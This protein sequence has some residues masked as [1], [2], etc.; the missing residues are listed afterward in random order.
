[1]TSRRPANFRAIEILGIL[2]ANG[3]VSFKTLMKLVDPP[4][5]EKKLRMALSRLLKKDVIQ[6]RNERVFGGHGTFYQ[7]SQGRR[8]RENAAEIL[9]CPSKYLEQPEFR[10]REL[11]HNDACAL[12]M[13]AIFH[14]LPD[15]QIIRDFEF[16]TNA[17][18]RKV[19]SLDIEDIDL[20]P[21]L[22]LVLRCDDSQSRIVSIAVE[23]EKTRKSDSRIIRKLYKY[24]NRSHV[25]GV[26]Y[27]CESRRI[28]DVLQHIFVTSVSH[29]ARR[30]EHYPQNFF[31]FS[32]SVDN[33]KTDKLLLWNSEE[34]LI[35]FL[36]WTHYLV[37]NSFNSRRDR[38]IA[39]MGESPSPF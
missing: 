8:D 11:L 30:I 13:N 24:A 31:L 22:L 36:D 23:I 19:M 34:K 10:Y 27:V 4:M 12:W 32:E 20:K 3:P 37:S 26:I 15:I 5:K 39:L 14:L 25:D 21:D 2:K 9:G 6:K 29:K 7:I 28:K 38:K 33:P 18:A 16:D 1:M 17:L 35:S